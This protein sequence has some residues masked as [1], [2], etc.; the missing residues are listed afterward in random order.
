MKRLLAICNGIALAATIAVNYLSNAGMLNGATMKT[1]SDKYAN[2][3]TPAGYAFSI[4]GLIYLGLLGIILYSW[5][6][7]ADHEN[8]L[9]SRI[10]WW[11]SISCLANSLW[12]VAW[13]YEQVGLSVLIMLV[14]FFSLIQIVRNLRVG[15]EQPSRGA[16]I[17]VHW[18]FSIYF[19]WVSVALIANIAAYLTKI[20]W[21]GWGVPETAWTVLMVGAAGLVNVLVVLR[22]RMPG[23]GLTGIWALLAIAAANNDAG[24]SRAVAS[25]CY[26]VAALVF[27][28]TVTGLFGNHA[29]RV[30]PVQ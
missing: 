23:F 5:R 7:I 27:V 18:P 22:R 25:A 9:L 10:G 14:L 26:I 30:E 11:F 12:V 15:Q 13:L 16:L 17:F 1:V 28:C 24:G 29:N 4:W 20:N 3:F 6:T 19:G 2:Y 21:D 8:Q